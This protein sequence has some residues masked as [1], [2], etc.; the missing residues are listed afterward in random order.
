VERIRRL[1][2]GQRGEILQPIGADAP[3]ITARFRDF[4]GK[5][6]RAL[7]ESRVTLGGPPF[8]SSDG[9]PRAAVPTWVGVVRAWADRA[10]P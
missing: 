1:D 2:R 9:Q 4:W 3:E 5:P 6:D 10:C 8:P 7:P